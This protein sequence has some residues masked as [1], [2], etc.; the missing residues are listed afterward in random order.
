M[1]GGASPDRSAAVPQRGLVAALAA[2]AAA[3]IARGTAVMRLT[4]NA[5]TFAAFAI[6]MCAAA[7]FAA[8]S[9]QGA[10][11]GAI[12]ICVALPIRQARTAMARA[13]DAAG[14]WL[15]ATAA[16]AAELAVYGALAASWTGAGP[17]RVWVFAITAMILLAAR[18]ATCASYASRPGRPDPVPAGGRRP[19]SSS[20]LRDGLPVRPAA[21]RPVPGRLLRLAGQSVALP[22]GERSVLIAV[23]APVWGPQV[24]LTVLIGW[25]VVAFF[26]DCAERA[27]AGRPHAPVT[28]GENAG[29][30]T[31]SG[32]R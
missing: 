16:T 18:Q 14:D 12:L 21:G 17:R 6:G 10:I 22:A 13:G 20:A 1:A 31:R 32:V 8:G 30:V 11:I 24:A 26:Y 5:L 4:P 2:P 7:W 9:G 15:A 27:V 19:A 3:V 23:T 29:V 25:S 28:G